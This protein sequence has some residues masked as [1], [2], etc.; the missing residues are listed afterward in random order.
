MCATSHHL[1]TRVESAPPPSDMVYPADEDHDSEMP[2]QDNAPL[3][4]PDTWRRSTL[5]DPGASEKAGQEEHAEYGHD[6]NSS[7]DE[8]RTEL[9]RAH[10]S[11]AGGVNQR[12]AAEQD[13]WMD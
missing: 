4:S 10:H 8:A 6:R 9:H 7:E 1:E 12:L 13:K 3:Q 11:R 5:A 2:D